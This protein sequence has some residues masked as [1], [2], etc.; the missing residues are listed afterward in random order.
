M[1]FTNKETDPWESHIFP[2]VMKLSSAEPEPK[3]KFLELDLGGFRGPCG[4]EG[5][6]GPGKD[7][8]PDCVGIIF[9]LVTVP[10]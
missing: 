5:T 6:L 8:G 4:L 10:V 9:S 2:A 1:F 3:P 7:R